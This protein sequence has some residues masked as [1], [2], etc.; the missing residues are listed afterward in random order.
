M[1]RLWTGVFLLAASWLLGTGYYYAPQWTAW[2]V[3]LLAGCAFV[4]MDRFRATGTREPAGNGFD[5]F[6]PGGLPGLL[7]V[8]LLVPPIWVAPWPYRAAPFLL[9]AGLLLGWQRR[10]IASTATAQAE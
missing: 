8:L 6:V 10:K 5:L 1:I 4:V 9:A 3:L 2:S 7:C